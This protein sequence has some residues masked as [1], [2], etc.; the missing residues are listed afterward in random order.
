MWLAVL[1]KGGTQR[2]YSLCIFLNSEHLKKFD[3]FDRVI[4]STKGIDNSILTSLRTLAKLN[5]SISDTFKVIHSK[6]APTACKNPSY[7]YKKELAQV[8]KNYSHPPM[9][10]SVIAEQNQMRS[11]SMGPPLR[12][13]YKHMVK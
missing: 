11:F 2:A 6:F 3:P 13:V 10:M 8:D 1:A 5:N 4:L 9:D 12:G 7:A